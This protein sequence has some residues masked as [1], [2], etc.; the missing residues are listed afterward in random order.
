MP[1][2]FIRELGIPAKNKTRT[3]R[4]EQNVYYENCIAINTHNVFC[5]LRKLENW[6]TAKSADQS[7]CKMSN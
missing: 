7:S 3:R 2:F 4:L 6:K 1:L 5:T